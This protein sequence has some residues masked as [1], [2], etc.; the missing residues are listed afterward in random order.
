MASN[1]ECQNVMEH[2]KHPHE[3][4]K[5]RGINVIYEKNVKG[6][7]RIMLYNNRALSM[8]PSKLNMECNGI[9][10][11]SATNEVI[12]YPPP[13]IIYSKDINIPAD[14][15]YSAICD[16]TSVVLYHY[17]GSWNL[18]TNKAY[19]VMNLK[20]PGISLTF[21]QMF[22]EI[23]NSETLEA[24]DQELAYNLIMKHHV[25][26]PFLKC[27]DYVVLVGAFDKQGNRCAVECGTF[28]PQEE[29]PVDDAL[30]GR[31]MPAY[32]NYLK[33]NEVIDFGFIV[34]MRGYRVL[35][36]SELMRKIRVALYDSRLVEYVREYK[37]DRNKFAAMY[38]AIR[39]DDGSFGNL[40]KGTE[41]EEYYKLALK[42]YN[43]IKTAVISHAA[44]GGNGII[45]EDC[46]N[47]YLL[48]TN[49]VQ[50]QNIVM[51]N[52]LVDDF[53]RSSQRFLI[54]YNLTF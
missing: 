17:R 33:N 45:P 25:M 9:I 50:P 4:F 20:P 31:L 14:A 10:L 3:Y 40:F 24:L 7:G 42:K 23:V 36:E 16:G 35:L 39:G 21:G 15:T 41:L 8:N 52:N 28:M 44:S 13:P 27:P 6:G 49:E 37:F 29:Y 2:E 43:Q 18:A 30:Y 54:L 26:H 5:K 11:D 48:L 32:T 1:L 53:L 46:R 38:A 22:A 34:N 51:Y 47:I 19:D 12:M